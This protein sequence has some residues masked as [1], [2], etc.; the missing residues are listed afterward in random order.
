[1]G[2]KQQVARSLDSSPGFLIKNPEAPHR[3][4]LPNWDHET[5]IRIWPKPH[6]DGGFECMREGSDDNNFGGAVWAEPVARSLGVKEQFTYIDRIP[7]ITG[8]TPTSRLIEAVTSLI[9]DKPREV[10]ESWIGWIKGGKKRAAKVQ[11]TKTHVFFQGMEIMRK[12]ELLQNESGQLQPMFPALVM[13]AVSLQMSF[14]ELANTRVQD[15]QGPMPES[16]PGDDA[17]ARTQLSMSTHRTPSSTMI[18]R[19]RLVPGY[20]GTWT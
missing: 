11:K 19:S 10:P 18:A 1:M 7:G 5:Q 13:G 14:E 17:A 9:E 3:T 8:K 4:V 12:G 16:I 6:A 15:F 2:Y 20:A